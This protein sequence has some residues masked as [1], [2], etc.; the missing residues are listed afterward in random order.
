M[1]KLK[2]EF[3]NIQIDKENIIIISLENKDEKYILY[4][5]ENITDN[6]IDK[7]IFKILEFKETLSITPKTRFNSLGLNTIYDKNTYSYKLTFKNMPVYY[8]IDSK[9]IFDLK[10]KPILT[11]GTL[12]KKTYSEINIINTNEEKLTSDNLINSILNKKK[13][14]YVLED[15][16]M[17][18]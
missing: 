11:N 1:R 8:S 6:D 12:Y 10:L 15:D 17:N 16:T 5:G 2:I 18:L 3:N 13:E 4:S 14:S 7:N 9:K